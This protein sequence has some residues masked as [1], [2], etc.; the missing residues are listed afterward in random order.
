MLNL[1]RRL[2]RDRASVAALEFG[3]IA[4]LMMV[5]FL[6]TIELTNVVRVQQKLNVTAGQFIEL[7]AGQA[8]VTEGSSRGPGGTLGDMCTGAALNMLPY[9][10][11]YIA[12]N[13][14]EDT[15]INTSTNG[16]QVKWVDAS[17]CPQAYN[18]GG[19]Y[20]T[21]A[22]ETLETSPLS[23]YTQNGSPSSPMVVGFS[24]IGV[25]MTYSYHNVVPFLLGPSITLTAT[26][27]ARPRVNTTVTCT[28]GTSSTACP[29][30]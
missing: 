20:G 21:P 27:V 26:A 8:T 4:P 14:S 28:I 30:S 1:C 23:L 17:S 11:N 5:L 15:A 19:F 12:A 2:I 18:A 9:N 10:P 6:G 24:A 7:V 13:I 25:I 29:G 16:E 22:L 3:L